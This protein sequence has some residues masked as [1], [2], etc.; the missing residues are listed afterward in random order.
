MLFNALMKSHFTLT[1]P[2]LFSKKPPPIAHTGNSG[3]SEPSAK[4]AFFSDTHRY[5][6]FL[7]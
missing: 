3:E 6:H 4:F 5:M 2:D 7:D 1:N